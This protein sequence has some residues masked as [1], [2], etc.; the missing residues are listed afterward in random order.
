M[1]TIILLIVQRNQTT[2]TS[3]NLI[4]AQL[5]SGRTWD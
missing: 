2:E 4:I 3:H 1:G 5:L